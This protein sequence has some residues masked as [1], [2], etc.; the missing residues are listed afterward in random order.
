MKKMILSSLVIF[1]SLLIF[2]SCKNEYN[3]FSDAEL[4]IN[5]LPI[6]LFNISTSPENT[7][8]LYQYLY[9][10]KEDEHTYISDIDKK[11][12]AFCPR[13]IK[14]NRASYANL[15]ESKIVYDSQFSYKTENFE[16][17]NIAFVYQENKFNKSDAVVV[18]S[19]SQF[20]GKWQIYDFRIINSDKTFLSDSIDRYF[21]NQ[22]ENKCEVY[23]K[24]KEVLM[25]KLPIKLNY[26]LANIE[27]D[28]TLENISYD[29]FWMKPYRFCFVDLNNDSVF[30]L[31]VECRLGGSSFNLVIREYDGKMIAHEFSHRQMYDLKKDGSFGASGGAAYSGY[32]KLDFINSNY[33]ID[34][35]AETDYMED[36]EG[37]GKAIFYVDD[38]LTD[39]D[40]FWI[41]WDQLISKESV[42]WIYFDRDTEEDL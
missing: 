32:Y 21:K 1:I 33:K 26:F 14:P 12:E 4:N 18:Y 3:Q 16:K 30:E 7:V 37:N 38:V 39:E 23:S 17:N 9:S 34:C 41:L 19:L 27:E 25:N 35:L 28:Y 10:I 24:Y 29:G 42:E 20:N 5:L 2:A 31:I 40:E 6:E 22:D 13:I 15:I 11:L 8:K 36:D